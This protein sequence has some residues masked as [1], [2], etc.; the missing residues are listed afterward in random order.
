[1]ARR[2]AP[3]TRVA[4]KPR[5]WDIWEVNLDPAKGRE[6]RG[7][8]AC[9]VISIDALN[10]SNF[11]TV[12]VCPIT[13]TFRESFT[14]RP[15]LV[16]EDLSVVAEDWTAKANWVETDQIATIDVRLGMRRMLATV[17]NPKKRA[18]VSDSVA[19]MLGLE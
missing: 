8:R 5:R 1:V 9:L 10:Q 11:G 7:V 2:S 15:G 6:Q 4:L 3:P 12:I 17:V 18:A 13:T 16:P 19:M 14:W